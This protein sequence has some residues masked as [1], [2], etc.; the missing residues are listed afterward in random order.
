[1]NIVRVGDAMPW[2]APIQ[3]ENWKEQVVW[4]ASFINGRVTGVQIM[5]EEQISA[6]LTEIFADSHSEMEVDTDISYDGVRW[7]SWWKRAA[8]REETRLQIRLER[9]QSFQQKAHEIHRRP[10]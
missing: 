4:S 9:D 5:E 7:W 3:N 2:P 8:K 1:M 6:I 10:C